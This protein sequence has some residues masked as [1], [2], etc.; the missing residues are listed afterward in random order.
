M[1]V[2][3]TAPAHLDA[4]F[5][6]L[7]PLCTVA[8]IKT[9]V[10]TAAP[11]PKLDDPER[12]KESVQIH[13]NDD[14][15]GEIRARLEADNMAIFDAAMRAARDRLYRN[16]QADVTWVDALIDV[17]RRSLDAEV[18][19]R[20]ARFRVAIWLDPN[21][22]V[23]ARWANGTAV[24]D[25]IRRHVTCDGWLSP[26]FTENARPVSVGR[27]QRI[28]PE[29]TRQ[30]VL[31]RDGERC[32]TPW[33]D[34]TY[35]LEIHHIVHWEDGGPTDTANLTLQCTICHHHI[36]RGDFHVHGNA[37]DPDGLIFTDRHGRPITR[38]QPK[39]PPE[40][41]PDP[42]NPYRHPLGERLDTSQLWFPPP[43]E[44]YDRN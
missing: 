11:P 30:A 16:G 44:S 15:S 13:H 33:C 25:A 5:A 9:M 18:P 43:P 10:R 31:H 40:P 34:R 24:P 36:H 1:A 12:P 4:K 26:T 28:V 23:R 39:P 8:Q 37:D 7:A 35:G 21:D 27:S 17:C 22:P 20:Q 19:S 2:A 32:R 29:R 6:S 3:V 38:P 42:P 41:A 14:G